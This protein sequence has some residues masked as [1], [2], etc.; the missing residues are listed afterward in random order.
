MYDPTIGRWLTEDPIGFAGEDMN[1]YRYVGNGPTN[2]TDP[3][4]LKSGK[5]ST[6]PVTPNEALDDATED[7]VGYYVGFF[8]DYNEDWNQGSAGDLQGHAAIGFIH[9]PGNCPPIVKGV[10]GFY[11]D[12]VKDDGEAEFEIGRVY[13]VTPKEFDRM[14]LEALKR[15][16]W[17]GKYD[18]TKR[19]CTTFV[20]DIGEKGGLLDGLPPQPLSAYESYSNFDKSGKLTYVPG[21]LG[22]FLKH[23]EKPDSFIFPTPNVPR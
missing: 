10:F 4:G 11:P 5:G 17:P 8:A 1:L 20:K 23:D 18:K 13:R 3:S 14:F 15:E 6:G 22:E 19:N 12:G 16:R 7:R 2:A 21:A 9:A